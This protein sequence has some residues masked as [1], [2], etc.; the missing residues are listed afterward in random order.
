MCHP[1][2]AVMVAVAHEYL[3]RRT[4]VTRL[5]RAGGVGYRREAAR[6]AGGGPRGLPGQRAAR[7]PRGGHPGRR[8]DHLRPADR[9]RAARP[10]RGARG[11]RRRP[12]GAP[13]DP[14]GRRGRTGRHPAQPVVLQLQRPAVARVR[15][16][17]PHLR[18]GRLEAAAA[19]AAHRRGAHPRHPRRDPPRRRRA[20]VGRRHPGGLRGRDP[21]ALA[22]RHPVPLRHQPDPVRALRDGRGRR[23]AVGL[24]LQLRVRRG[25][26]RR[27]R[28]PGALPR[29]RRRHA[30]AHQGR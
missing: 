6:V 30:L 4:P 22:H 19:P 11:H 14:V 7:L 28:A 2:V 15:R 25:A 17:R 20:V 10:R 1:G 12:H 13:E 26:A 8:Q 27:R 18:A 21:A 24:G 29:L 16:R 9:H 5:P 3:S 23:P